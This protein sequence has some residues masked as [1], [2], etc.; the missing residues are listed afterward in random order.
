MNYKDILRN[1][2]LS[3]TNINFLVTTVLTNFKISNKAI[4][5][6]TTIIV[7]NLSKYLENIDRYPENNNELIEAINFL[8]KKCYDDFV[9]YLMGKYPN[10]NFFRNAQDTDTPA[11]NSQENYVSYVESYLPIQEDYSH[12]MHSIL[13]EPLSQNTQP[14][15]QNTQSSLQNTQPLLQNTQSSLQNSSSFTPCEEVIIITE[16]EK[17]NLLKKYGIDT[18]CQ[19]NVKPKT[20]CDDILL[21]LT[22]PMVFQMFSMM[23][24]QVKQQSIHQQL[25]IDDIIDINQVAELLNKNVKTT[26]S[27]IPRSGI[28]ESNMDE[29]LDEPIGKKTKPIDENIPQLLNKNIDD[30]IESN[31]EPD[32][33]S[34]ISD[35]KLE[36]VET[37]TEINLENLTKDDLPILEKKLKELMY[38]KNKHL[39]EKNRSMAKKIDI[40]KDSI[41]DAIKRY[42]EELQRQVDENKNKIN[43]MTL[44]RKKVDDNNIEYLDLKF[45]PTNDYNDLKNIVISFKND[46][47]ITDITLVDYYLP[48]NSN[49]VT[50]FNNKFK[51]FFNDTINRFII[52]PGKYE[53]NMLIDYIKSQVS[54]L[55][56]SINDNNIIMVKNSLCMKFDLMIENDSIF[57]VLGF[58]TK[59]EMHKDKLFY[60]GA[61]PYDL[62]CN[63]KILFNLSGSTMDPMLMEFDKNVKIDKSIKKSRAGVS[64]K[65]MVLNLTN[66]LGQYYDLHLPFNMCF[67]I[68][69]LK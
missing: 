44:K 7:N 55:D 49:N 2:L 68:T 63:E 39:S 59:V 54:F 45:D 51:V 34:E 47:K 52:P 66:G 20:N 41:I 65:Q 31:K 4:T 16:D 38:L 30:K 58:S 15:S 48:F 57:Q 61:R 21:Y 19:N 64:I 27:S 40:E 50:R 1:Q 29:S 69:Y 17:D 22:N 53:I 14:L 62:N 26:Y 32:I 67:K 43:G 11:Q 46:D 56:F 35:H 8:N 24:S 6:C 13:P 33:A 60:S 28:N 3:Q 23:T 10:V 18:R 25:V 5:K 42:K 36:P 37:K 12:V 9:I